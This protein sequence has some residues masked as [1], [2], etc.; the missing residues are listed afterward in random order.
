[1]TSG[2]RAWQKPE[3]IVL[4]RGRSEEAVLGACKHSTFG[5]TSTPDHNHLMCGYFDL[6]CV[7]CE[8]LFDS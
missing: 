2:K 7:L 5:H 1:M 8:L 6:P 4:V 3:L